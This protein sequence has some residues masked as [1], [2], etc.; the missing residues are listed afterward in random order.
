MGKK[1]IKNNGPTGKATAVPKSKPAPNNPIATWI[2][3]AQVLLQ[4]LENSANSL[5][6]ED[7][8]VSVQGLMDRYKQISIKNKVDSKREELL[9]TEINEF[10]HRNAETAG[11]AREIREEFEAKEAKL[12]KLDLLSKH[13]SSRLRSVE[14]KVTD[15][16]KEEKESRL[17]MSY[18]FSSTIKDISQKLDQLGKKRE[19]IVTENSRLK[20]VLRECLEE[21]D[22]DQEH[23]RALELELQE[24]G[25]D[26]Q[27]DHAADA[28]G[29]SEDKPSVERKEMEMED[30]L[31]RIFLLRSKE[32]LLKSHTIRFME[33]F[34]SFQVRLTKSNH[35]FQVKQSAVEEMTKRIKAMEKGNQ[36][37]AVHIND[38]SSS[39]KSIMDSVDQLRTEKLKYDKMIERQKAMID[40]FQAD[41]VAMESG[42]DCK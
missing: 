8:E 21:F 40:K 2:E 15:D 30:D 18:E 36:H 32:D 4:R 38:C 41:I 1:Q 28:K 20:Q 6:A 9:Q 26:S 13:L 12:D 17:K 35:L 16:V 23:Q 7:S 22:K 11:E 19:H 3:E 34:D 37:L 27:V 14:S 5:S 31:S 29:A 24:S 39:S 10:Q 42:S 33:I 25:A